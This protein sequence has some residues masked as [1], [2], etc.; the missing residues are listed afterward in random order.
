[1]CRAALVTASC[2]MRYVARSAL[3][4]RSTSSTSRSTSRPV[5]LMRS[6][7]ASSPARVGDAGSV[8]PGPVGGPEHAQD[9]VELTE[10]H[11]TDVL[12]VRERLPGELRPLVEHVAADAGL[13]HHHVDGVA[14]RVVELPGQA[15]ALLQDEPLHRRLLLP[16]VQLGGGA[17][18]GRQVPTAPGAVPQ[19]HGDGERDDDPEDGEQ[20]Q[21]AP[22]GDGVADEGDG[23]CD[24]G[25][26][27][28]PP[29][30]AREDRVE[31]DPHRVLHDAHGVAGG[32]VHDD[33]RARR[34]Q[35]RARRRAPPP[36]R[37]GGGED[38]DDRAHVGLTVVRRRR[39]PQ[40]DHQAGQRHRA[41]ED[42]VDDAR[43]AGVEPVVRSDRGT[44]DAHGAMMHRVPPAG[45]HPRGGPPVP[46]RG[47]ATG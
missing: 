6:Q 21:R 25:A 27:P 18:G 39:W 41:D 20:V 30:R 46:A 38:K 45:R 10:R 1:M 37:G 26:H 29:G 8:V 42:G 23:D 17:L 24:H 13:H 28:V 43:A 36:H 34:E 33:D 22:V 16:L 44:D 47:T 40:Q 31:R 14:D 19:E 15:S 12:H 11:S 7:R 32:G 35:R 9:G 2:T 3:G 5:A 4:A